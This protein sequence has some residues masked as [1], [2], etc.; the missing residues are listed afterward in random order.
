MP[1]PFV[2]HLEVCEENDEELEMDSVQFSEGDLA[3]NDNDDGRY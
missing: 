2:G 1:E 3:E